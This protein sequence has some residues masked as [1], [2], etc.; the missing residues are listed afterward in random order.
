M[1]S[2]SA[3]LD[4]AAAPERVWRA[5]IDFERYRAWHP[6]VDI[7]GVAGEGNKIEYFYRKDPAAPRNWSIDAMINR[8]E[9]QQH[10]AINFGIAGLCHIEQWYALE[11]IPI[12][13][14][15]THGGTFRGVVPFL[16]G[17]FVRK[18]MRPIYLLP[19]QRLARRLEPR[20]A[21]AKPTPKLANKP[22]RRPKNRPRRHRR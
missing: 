2:V 9:D 18:R 3:H 8:L 20:P 5:L 21:A 4:I 22:V 11:P 17:R 7:E 16:A 6:F 14:R 13:T 1:F 19:L 15:L 12:G 10:F